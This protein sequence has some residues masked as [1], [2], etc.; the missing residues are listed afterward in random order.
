MPTT[1]KIYFTDAFAPWQR[2]SNEERNSRIREYYPKGTAFGH[3]L[4]VRLNAVTKEIN[5][6]P[7]GV[8]DWHSPQFEF[9]MAT[10]RTKHKQVS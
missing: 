6:K 9:N 7:M 4:Q 8:L 3:E 1:K 10:K 2:G 5:N